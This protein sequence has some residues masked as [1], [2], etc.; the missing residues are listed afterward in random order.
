MSTD[1]K[2]IVTK[3]KPA[4]GWLKKHSTVVGIVLV[5]CLYGWIVIE[6]NSLSRRE[7]S[8][9][10]I[11]E[12]LQTIKRPRID[13]KTIDKIEQLQDNNVQVEALFKSARENPFQE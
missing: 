10:A 6:I 13:Q 9:D 8:E 3:I 7:P 2:D 5:L 12:K 11:N 1:I 4:L